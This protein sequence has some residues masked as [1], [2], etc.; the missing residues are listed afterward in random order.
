MKHWLCLLC[1]LLSFNAL[2]KDWS[3]A[4]A[5][6]RNEANTKGLTSGSNEY[7]DFVRA[8]A[9]Q[10]APHNP[11][12]SHYLCTADAAY[13][14][15]AHS[16]GKGKGRAVYQ[17]A[18]KCLDDKLPAAIA[19]AGSNSDLKA[20]IKSWHAKAMTL[21]RSPDDRL[22]EKDE[23]EAASVLEMEGKTAGVWH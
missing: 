1:I 3:E 22:V 13:E 7:A 14:P 11:V 12:L 23:R 15:I 4:A 21:M 19:V 2:A 5:E 17:D 20:A 16:M 8:C 6:C 18:L 9:D 10:R